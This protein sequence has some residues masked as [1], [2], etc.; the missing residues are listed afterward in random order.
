MAR[1]ALARGYEWLVISDH[2]FGLPLV[3]GMTEARVL[4]QRR[5]IAA[6]NHK[7]A[8]FRILQGVELEIR[9]DGTLD[10]DDAFLAGFDVVGASLHTG[11]QRDGERNTSRILQALEDTE[12]D[13]IN[14]PTG[15]IVGKREAYELDVEQVIEEAR[16]QGK[17]LEI[18]GNERLDLP[19][20]MVRR[21]RERG[22]RF[23]LSSDAHGADQLPLIRYAVAMARRGWLERRHVLNCLDLRS[24]LE[25]VRPT[26][27]RTNGL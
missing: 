23:T 4:E 1:A 7:L 3:G 15:R 9:P 6:L 14:H 20:E 27:V 17:T 8:P 12:V 26:H 2:S 18:N 11:T 25:A 22:I 19:S 10:F 21:A 5:E 24:L 13:G 16:R